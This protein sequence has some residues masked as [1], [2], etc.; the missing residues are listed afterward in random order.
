MLTFQA[1][2][3]SAHETKRLVEIGLVVVVLVAA[4]E[5]DAAG[6][7]GSDVLGRSHDV[8]RLGGNV[9]LHSAALVNGE[10]GLLVDGASEAVVVLG[11]V[12]I[13]GIVL[14]VVDVVLGAVAADAVGGDLELAG[15][16]AKGHEAEDAEEQADGLGGDGLDGADVDGLGV[17]AEPVAKVNAGDH[18]FAK[19]F[20]V[21]GLGHGNGEEGILN[22]TVTPSFVLEEA[23]GQTSRRGKRRR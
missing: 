4:A 2:K 7:E 17:V 14:G 5:L 19:L 15:A 23:G 3:T 11:G 12:D 1:V 10:L 16:V 13:V 20:A 18:D 6:K 8:I 22:V 9:A 21:E